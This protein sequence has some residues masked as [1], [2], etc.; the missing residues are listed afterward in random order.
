MFSRVQAFGTST[1][2]LAL[3]F[4]LIIVLMTGVA[5]LGLDQ[6]RSLNEKAELLRQQEIKTDQVHRMRNAVRERFIRLGLIVISDDPFLQDAYIQEFDLLASRFMVARNAI[7]SR[8]SHPDEVALLQELRALTTMGS[9]VQASVLEAALAGDNARAKQIMF[10]SSVPIQEQVMAQ[11]DRILAFFEKSNAA[12]LAESEQEQQ[13]AQRLMTAMAVAQ[14]MLALLIAMIVIRHAHRQHTGMQME[15]ARRRQSEAQLRETQDGLERQVKERTAELDQFKSTLDRTLDCVFMFDA[16]TLRFF[17]FNEGAL[18]QVGYTQDELLAMHPFDIKPDIN[19]AQFRELIAPLLAGEQVSR[20]FE[21]IHQHKNG[22]RLPVEIFL[23]Y[24]APADEAARFVAIVRD[25]TERKASELEIHESEQRFRYM[26][27]TCPTA[28]RIARAGGHDVI[29]SNRRYAELL[30]ADSGKISGV[31]PATY[32]AHPEDYADILLRL[33]RGEQIFDRLVELAIPGAGTK[34]ALAS[35]LPL[36]YQGGAAVLGWFY[37]ITERK[38][39]ETALREQSLHTQA[40]LDHMVDGLI[41]IDERGI[42]DSFNPAAERIFGYAST[43][44]LGQNVKMLAPNPHRD[45]HDSYLRNYQTT[46]VARIIGIGREVEGQRKDGTLFPMELAI[47]EITRHGRPMYVGMVRDITERKRADR[48]KSE[49][50]STVSHELRTPLTSISGALGLITGG[51]LGEIP[52]QAREMIAIAHKNSQRLS[53][54]INDLLDM[55]KITAGKLH[56]DMQPQAL[57]PLISQALEANRAYGAERRVALALSGEVPDVDVRVDS[58]RLMQVLSNLLSNAVKFSPDGGVVEVS[59]DCVAS[60]VCVSVRDH[61]SG[62]PKAFSDRIFQKFAQADSSDTR[63]K[64]GTGLGLAITRELVER[65]GGRIGFESV[66]GEGARFFFELPIWNA[67]T[68][69]PV[70]APLPP[71]APRILVVEDEPD[72]ARLLSLML[73]RA[74]YMVDIAA[75]GAA[76]LDAIKRSRYA[77]VT[78]DL[79]LPDISGLAIIRQLRQQPETADLPIVVVS[80]KMEEGRLTIN[81]DFSDIDWLAKPFDE[82]RLLGIVDR[83]V[84]AADQRHPRVLHVEDDS[85]LH[86]VIRAMIGRRFDF[87]IATTLAEAWARVALERFDVVI[88]DLTLPDGSGWD[89]LPE[90]RARQPEARVVILSGSDMTEAEALKVE[91]VLLKSQ[92]SPRQLL[93]A[94]NTRIQPASSKGNDS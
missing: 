13:R 41:T 42:I 31:D 5:L 3:A 92:V 83:L 6:V 32:Y 2:Y 23:Q 46:G 66:E 81:S 9:P 77:A 43:E 49:F 69:H 71:D 52:A 64:G 1:P 62:V 29:F 51:A 89:L 33:G 86:Q 67:Q 70:T 14:A 44:M 60:T 20:T 88:L 38:Q 54:L 40:I 73:R 39:A 90:I 65:M 35:Y 7:E 79:M 24:I 36:Q 58:Q 61:G 15:I 84:S 93:N 63:K 87:E 53:H 34:W 76:A 80:A 85:D 22:Q 16:A 75:S 4:V 45:A 78:L 68:S 11:T 25:I 74:G 17:Y 57:R 72:V 30:N 48:M 47:S 12:I 91:A 59:V 8:A 21:T 50:V 55:E 27:E 26:L 19:E 37:D 56:F 82:S 18:R 10:E 28:A 94:L